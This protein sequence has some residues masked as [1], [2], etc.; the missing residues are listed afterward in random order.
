MSGAPREVLDTS[1]LSWF[2]GVMQAWFGRPDKLS[3]IR[4][5][6]DNGRKIEKWVQVE[7]GAALEELHEHSPETCG[8]GCHELDV[9][10]CSLY[11]S[12]SPWHPGLPWPLPPSPEDMWVE[13]RCR[14][15]KDLQGMRGLLADICT[16]VGKQKKR[17]RQKGHIGHF[18][19]AAM[20][21]LE[22][23]VTPE[24]LHAW[25]IVLANCPNTKVLFSEI[26]SDCGV[27]VAMLAG[28]EG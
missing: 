1:R 14:T 21:F 12:H 9:E 16:D 11:V 17:K 28:W 7:A 20:I 15:V 18:I 13:F 26:K 8:F 25:K 4:Q 5:H 22:P 27:P 3:V 10:K 6:R 24:V 2:M 19:A 23:G